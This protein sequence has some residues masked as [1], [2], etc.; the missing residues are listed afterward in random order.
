[1]AGWPF[2]VSLLV[3]AALP[4]SHSL[5]S[6]RAP[7][8][9]V[10]L[11][12]GRRVNMRCEGVGKPVV[13]FESG[14]GAQSLAWHKVQ[15]LA[16]R[17][18]RTCSYDRAGYG[19]SDPGP[20]PRDG[21]SIARDLDGALRSAKIDGPFV[22]VGH[23]TGGLYMRLF[24]DRRP[25][26]ITAMVLADPSIPYQEQRFGAAFGRGAGSIAGLRARHAK[27]LV[28][29]PVPII[30]E[31][32]RLA[33]CQNRLSELDS[34][35]SATSAQI[36]ADTRSKYDFPLIVLT[37]DRTFSGRP[38]AFWFALHDEVAASS[39]RGSHRLVANSSHM[40]M[41]D[42]PDAIRA[43]IDEVVREARKPKRR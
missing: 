25:G 29:P 13:L 20:L 19:L 34:L 4:G 12:D 28:S 9:L 37:A 10:R 6:A 1:M 36:G 43:A 30:D 8:E 15:P 41:F 26:E 2:L 7:G 40:M 32:E 22:L 35:W 38:A 14:F 18:R 24:A 16:A 42:Q 23:S 11:S 39:K 3:L 17:S 27:C 5:A 31:P 33:R 21:A